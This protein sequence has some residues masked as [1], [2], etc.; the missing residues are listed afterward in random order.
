MNILKK[1][2]REVEEEHRNTIQWSADDNGSI[3]VD[4]DHL[5]KTDAFQQ[6]VEDFAELENNLDK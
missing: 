6:S 5:V 4:I 1:L 2:Y 3:I